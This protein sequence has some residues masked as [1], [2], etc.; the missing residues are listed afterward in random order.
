MENPVLHQQEPSGF[1]QREDSRHTGASPEKIGVIDFSGLSLAIAHGSSPYARGREA[2]H[3]RTQA[4]VQFLTAQCCPTAT[5]DSADTLT[6]VAKCRGH[7]CRRKC[8]T[9][10]ARA[11]QFS[12]QPWCCVS[13]TTVSGGYFLHCST[14]PG[15]QHGEAPSSTSQAGLFSLLSE[16]VWVQ[17]LDCLH[18]MHL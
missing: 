1:C 13:S 8:V 4:L 9:P 14:M 7:G 3:Y 17:G 12:G 16:R 5:L 15:S 11:M 10:L 6:R 18:N 2:L